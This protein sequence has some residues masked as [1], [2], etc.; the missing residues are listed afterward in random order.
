MTTTRETAPAPAPTRI[1]TDAMKLVEEWSHLGDVMGE[2]VARVARR[3]GVT[4]EWLRRTVLANTSPAS[5]AHRSMVAAWARE[6]PSTPDAR[7]S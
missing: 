4:E 3:H 1:S 2:T 7:A 5:P 6:H